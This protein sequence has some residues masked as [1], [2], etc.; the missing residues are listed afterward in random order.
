[1]YTMVPLD[2]YYNNCAC[3]CPSIFILTFN[4]LVAVLVSI[5]QKHLPEIDKKK[6]KLVKEFNLFNCC[7]M[8]ICDY[9]HQAKRKQSYSAASIIFYVPNTLWP[10]DIQ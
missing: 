5:K 7:K 8:F 3:S 1:M 6:M 9:I 2:V 10:M 4:D